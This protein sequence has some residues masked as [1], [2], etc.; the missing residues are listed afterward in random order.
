MR[1]WCCSGRKGHGLHCVRSAGRFSRHHSIND[2]I[3]RALISAGIPSILEPPGLSRSDG[4]RPDGLTMVPWE[5]G[6]YLLWD[7]TC[8]CTFAPSHLASSSVVSGAAAEAAARLKVLKYSQLLPNYDFV[9]V[10][11]ETAGVW[12]MQGKA[13]IKE[14]GRRLRIRGM[15][16][17]SGS[18]LMQRISIAVQRGNAASVVACLNMITSLTL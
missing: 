10:A 4:K 6:R 2:I 9:P 11:L 7:A 3:R 16:I 14:I 8:V 18:Y 12:G 5:K 13:F 15:D 1:V 17:R